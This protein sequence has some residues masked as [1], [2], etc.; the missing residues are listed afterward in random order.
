[1]IYKLHILQC[2]NNT[3]S[4]K[5]VVTEFPK[6][7]SRNRKA[8][9]I[10][11]THKR[12]AQQVIAAIAAG[13][14]PA[15]SYVIAHVEAPTNPYLYILVVAALGYSAPTLVTWSKKWA[16]HIAKATGFAILLEGVMVLSHIEA[17]SLT[18]L[19]IL[20]LINSTTAFNKA[21]TK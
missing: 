2:M 1:M 11:A 21:V 18:G 12:S 9:A 19:T 15:A 7:N 14:L 20:V 6:S 17:L 4:T 3:S 8:P 10:K 5:K 16:G 13:F